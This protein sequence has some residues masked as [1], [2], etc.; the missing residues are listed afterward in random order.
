MPGTGGQ[1][2]MTAP[3]VDVEKM[4]IVLYHLGG[5]FMNLFV[6]LTGII[7]FFVVKTSYAVV[8]MIFLMFAMT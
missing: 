7:V 2:I 8:G 4:P 1:C 5:L 3:K 6:F